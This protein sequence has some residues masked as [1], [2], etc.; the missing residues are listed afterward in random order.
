MNSKPP[1]S[2]STLSSPEAPAVNAVRTPDQA[3]EG[4]PLRILVV[5]D[6]T[7]V[8]ERLV[9]MLTAMSRAVEVKRA[10]TMMMAERLFVELEP[11]VAILDLSLP[12][13]SGFNLLRQFKELRPDCLV[14]M[15]TTY[16]FPE[17]R[18][19]ARK[20]GADHF[21]SKGTEFE[22]VVEVLSNYEP[23]RLREVDP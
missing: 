15:L 14:I 10:E 23:D 1:T 19:N 18:E 8:G 5:E 22:R 3:L 13:G 12:D 6:S 9:T 21:F 20:L 11:Q 4:P 2:R 7:I 16:G 17:F